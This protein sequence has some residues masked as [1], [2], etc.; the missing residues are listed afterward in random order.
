[1]AVVS[2]G[3]IGSDGTVFTAIGAVVSVVHQFLG[4]YEINF[5]SFQL[6]FVVTQVTPF[7]PDTRDNAVIIHNGAP[8]NSVIVKTGDSNGNPADR[9]FSFMSISAA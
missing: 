7:E 3:T 6:A 9:S 4:H 1:M 8:G 5:S 2:G